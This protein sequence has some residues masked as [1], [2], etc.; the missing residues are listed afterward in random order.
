MSPN[1]HPIDFLVFYS[2]VK[3]AQSYPTLSTP[4]TIQ[5]MEFSRLEYRSRWP[6]PGDP[7]DQ[8]SNQGLLHCGQTLYQLSYEGSPIV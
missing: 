1:I 5:Y 2:V 4:W 7:P 3:V 8:E 6:S